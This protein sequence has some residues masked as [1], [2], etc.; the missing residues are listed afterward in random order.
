MRIYRSCIKTRL[1]TNDRWLAYFRWKIQ[2]IRVI[3]RISINVT[4]DLT[5]AT[6]KKNFREVLRQ[7]T[8]FFSFQ[9]ILFIPTIFLNKWHLTFNESPGILF[10][11]FYLS[12]SDNIF[13]TNDIF[14]D[15]SK[16]I[17]FPIVIQ[18]TFE[19]LIEL[20]NVKGLK[21]NPL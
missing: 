5:F 6:F 10:T 3:E 20:I 12:N 9:L 14:H 16:S 8:I 15:R 13:W 21:G 2:V 11:Y 18:L 17:F 7:T 4:N 1:L 19:L